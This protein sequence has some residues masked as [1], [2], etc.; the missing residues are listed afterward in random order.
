MPNYKTEDIRNIALVGHAYSGKTTLADT[1]LY[2]TGASNRKGSVT[3]KTSVM[4]FEDEEKDRGYSVDS[5]VANVQHKG[6]LINVV[7]A[8]GAP[9]FSGTAIAALTA[10]ETAVCVISAAEGIGVNTRR[11]MQYAGDYGVGR[12]I[13]ITHIDSD[14]INLEELLNTLREMYGTAVVPLNLPAGGGKSVVDCLTSDSGDS[15]IED[16]ADVHQ[17]LVDAIVESDEELME[18]Y[19]ETGEISQDK[20]LPAVSQAITAGKL[21]PV[22]FTATRNEVG[23]REL[24]DVIADFM[25]SPV[26]GMQRGVVDGESTQIV[27]PDPAGTFV[28]QV[29]KVWI[30][31]KSNIKYSFFRVLSGTATADLAAQVDDDRKG[32]RLGHILKFQ[33]SEHKDIDSGIPGD[34][35]AVA[36]LDLHMGQMLHGG[37]G[38]RVPLPKFPS[39]ML[40]VAIEPKSRGDEVKINEAL[41]KLSDMDPCFQTGRDPQTSELI[42][43][44]MGDLHLRVMLSR[45]NRFSKVEVNTKPPKIPYRE[46]ITAKADGH[47]RHKK[48][49]GGAGQFGEVFL[50]VEPIERGSDPSLEWDW[51][52]FGGTIPGQFEPAIRKGVDDLLRDGAI[53][54]YP[55]QDLKV[56]ITDGKHHPVDSKEVAFRIAGKLALRDAVSKAKP[57]ILEPIVKLEVTCPV[58]N[59][60]DITGDL[61]S[62]RGRPQGQET[63][64]GG[65]ATIIATTP[66]SEVSD[67]SG[68]LSSMTG[69]QGSYVIEFS[70]FEP[71]PPQ[72]QQQLVAA[73]KP[74]EEE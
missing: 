18:Q 45:M 72:V 53:A 26:D 37:V 46:T 8:P 55:L 12:A 19:L 39:P 73:F 13:V 42:A 48:Q 49:T 29:F 59:V 6:K 62:R 74:K 9:D 17:K 34:L 24:L 3:D 31:P 23:V 36:K 68:R 35:V 43:S 16:V 15:D 54:G 52:I 32:Q 7:D 11:M 20:L 2:V 1:I 51:A 64:P 27:K 21:I 41:S 56:S 66:L 47:Y 67:Y 44:G 63:L 69:G 65:M 71:V 28:A 57:V 58:D 70:H 25:P 40:S 60:G 14:N 33:G 10:V 22:M 61:A 38:G 4:D 50:R 30:E 5:A